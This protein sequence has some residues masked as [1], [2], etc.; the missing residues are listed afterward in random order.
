MTLAMLRHITHVAR[1]ATFNFRKM[2]NF[3]QRPPPSPMAAEF[4][5]AEIASADV[6]MFSKDHCPFCTKAQ[7]ALK[8]INQDFK[9]IELNGRS[10]MS[11]IQDALLA[12]TGARSVPRVF[13]KGQFYGGGDETSAGCKNGDFQKKLA[14]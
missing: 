9:L 12:I 8:S 10:D 14:A 4:V 11:E 3:F 2:G 13:V 1:P 6:V 5:K 7:N